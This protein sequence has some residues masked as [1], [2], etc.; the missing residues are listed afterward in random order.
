MHVVIG[1]G[2]GLLAPKPKLGLRARSAFGQD[3]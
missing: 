2:Y 3:G 1:R